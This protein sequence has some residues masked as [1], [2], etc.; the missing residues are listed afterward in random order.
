M[1]LVKPGKGRAHQGLP[2]VDTLT[3]QSLK[4][5]LLLP[6]AACH[7]TCCQLVLSFDEIALFLLLK[8]LGGPLSPKPGVGTSAHTRAHYGIVRRRGND[9]LWAGFVHVCSVEC[10]AV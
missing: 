8:L 6:Q 2:L 4:G 9:H 5:S 10:T 1:F 7:S 3:L